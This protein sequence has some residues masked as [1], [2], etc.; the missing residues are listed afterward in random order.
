MDRAIKSDKLTRYG[1]HLNGTDFSHKNVLI[2]TFIL[3]NKTKS[4]INPEEK[5]FWN[6]E[7]KGENAGSQHFFPFPTMF[8]KVILLKTVW[9]RIGG[10]RVYRNV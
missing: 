9:F 8:S 3:Y 2:L 6:I 1:K 10:L 5:Y 7:G 4:L